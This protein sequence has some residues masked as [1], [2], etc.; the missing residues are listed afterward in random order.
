MPTI[1]VPCKSEP[2][3]RTWFVHSQCLVFQTAEDGPWS[4]RQSYSPLSSHL[5]SALVKSQ[6]ACLD[7]PPIRLQWFAALTNRDSKRRARS[8]HSAGSQLQPHPRTEPAPCAKPR[9]SATAPSDSAHFSWR[10]ARPTRR[11]NK[12]SGG[13]CH[14]RWS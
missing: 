5:P 14:S 7:C 6:V 10:T 11:G 8:G 9:R 1:A 4:A 12:W 2:E 13:T 3:P